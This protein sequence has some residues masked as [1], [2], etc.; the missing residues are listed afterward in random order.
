MESLNYA[1][2]K[3]SMLRELNNETNIRIKKLKFDQDAVKL[4]KHEQK[5]FAR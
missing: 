5:K 4:S 1:K 3:R 2:E